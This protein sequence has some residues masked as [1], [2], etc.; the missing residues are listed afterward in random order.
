MSEITWDKL[1][2]NEQN[3]LRAFP[4]EWTKEDDLPEFES[5]LVNSPAEYLLMHNLIAAMEIGDEDKRIVYRRTP[6][7]RALVASQPAVELRETEPG[8]YMV[9]AYA[10]GDDDPY[11]YDA[12]PVDERDLLRARVLELEA[13]LH[14]ILMAID[15]DHSPAL[16]VDG[17]KMLAEVALKGN[18]A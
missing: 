14:N 16:K 2:T 8:V 5:D 18:R 1:S 11:T 4:D 15:T 10:P 3:L 9:D 6:A 17:I 12:P 7:G 13:G